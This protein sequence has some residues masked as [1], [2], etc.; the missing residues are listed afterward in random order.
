MLTVVVEFDRVPE[1][2]FV[3]VGEDEFPG[4]AAVGGF[5]EAGEVPFAR[6]H[7][8]GGALVEGLDS[9]EVEVFGSGRCGAG[10]PEVASVL[11]AE[12]GAVGSA[13]PGDSSAYVVD[14]AQAGGGVG[15][16]EVPLGLGVCCEGDQER[17]YEQTHVRAV[18][19]V[20][21]RAYC[22]EMRG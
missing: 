17:E 11:G 22:E 15:V 9:A 19:R 18:Y 16:L 4:F 20:G 3:W 1:A 12:D 13:G 5:V 6:G 21:C 14:S 2:V 8:D 7:D 10:L